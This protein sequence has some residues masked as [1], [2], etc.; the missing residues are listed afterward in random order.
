MKKTRMLSVLAFAFIGLY[1]ISIAANISAAGTISHDVNGDQLITMQ[2]A[3]ERHTYRFRQRTSLTIEGTSNMTLN[4]NVD[5]E[6]IG[7][8]SVA[9]E[10]NCTE[11]V[12]LNMT[13]NESEAELGL[14]K[15]NTVQ[16]RNRMRYRYNYGFMANMSINCTNFTAKLKAEVNDNANYA[17]AYYDEEN[18]EWVTVPTE[19]TG[20]EAVAEVDH[21][22]T[23]T[24][25]IQESS[26]GI[27]LIVSLTLAFTALGIVLIMV[28]KRIR[29]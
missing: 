28:H 1:I 17:W 25:L 15:G 19:V 22:S 8:K 13:C 7:D 12:E 4:M 6:S 9:I 14:L 27:D 26:I 16:T 2:Q 23:W 24:L 21:F 20:G 5:S 18:D 3:H 10:I 29:K 11:P